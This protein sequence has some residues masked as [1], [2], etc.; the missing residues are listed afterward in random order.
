MKASFPDAS[1]S[2]VLIILSGGMDSGVLLLDLLKRKF[3]PL[4]IT[5]NYEAKHSCREIAAAKEL[6]SKFSIS[7]EV[8]ELSFINNYLSSS[9]LKSGTNVPLGSY[10]DVNM[11]STVVPFRNGIMLSIAAGIAESR[12]IPFIFIGTHAGDSVVYPDCRKD[13]NKSM[14][15]AIFFGTDSK[16]KFFAPYEKFT[17]KEIATNGKELDFPFELSWT[18]YV[19]KEKQCGECAACISRREAIGEDDLTAYLT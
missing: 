2:N 11:S 7:H 13:F 4:A 8:I 6:T 18:C 9:L 12:E 3:K 15:E 1:G 5:F 17:K 16:I 14:N 10:S 19:G